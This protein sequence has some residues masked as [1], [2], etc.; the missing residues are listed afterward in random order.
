MSPF[1]HNTEK[2][3]AVANHE[4]GGGQIFKEISN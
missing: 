3:Q 1:P 2:G 4:G